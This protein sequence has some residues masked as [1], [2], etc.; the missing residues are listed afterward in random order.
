[1][2]GINNGE[3]TTSFPANIHNAKVL[4]HA[5]AEYLN[6]LL[7][8]QKRTKEKYE[9]QLIENKPVDG[10]PEYGKGSPDSVYS[11]EYDKHKEVIR[12]VIE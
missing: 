2:F 12:W 8:L 1:M 7:V 10:E 6:G 5:E 4:A 9:S 11:D 3:R